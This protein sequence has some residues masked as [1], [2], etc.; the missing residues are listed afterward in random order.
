MFDKLQ[1]VT[2]IRDCS[3][4]TDGQF[5]LEPGCGPVDGNEEGSYLT[6]LSREG[7]IFGVINI[8]GNFGTVF[9]DQ[10]YWQSAIA[11]KP[12]SSHKGYLLGGMCWF[13]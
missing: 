2:K 3:Y 11:A 12:Q 6:M 10:S 13:T 9:V 8:V 5:T 1:A 7:F 4:G